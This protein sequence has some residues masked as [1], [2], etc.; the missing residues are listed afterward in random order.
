[1]GIVLISLDWLAN[2]AFGPFAESVSAHRPCFKCHWT[3]KCG[4]A[5]IARTDARNATI[6]HTAL[7]RRKRLRTHDETMQTVREMRAMDASQL[8]STKTEEGLF[9]LYFASEYLL[10]D[11]V[12]DA[13]VDI[14]H[15]FLSSGVVPYHLSWL[16]DILIPA[17]FSWDECNS[18]VR[19]YNSKRK[20]HHIPKIAPTAKSDRGSAKLPLTAGE[21]MEFAVASAQI[22]GPLVKDHGTPHWV[23]WLKLVALLRFCLRR[24]FSPDMDAR[25]VQ[26]LYDDWMRSIEHVPQWKGRWKPKHH[27]G[28]HLAQALGEHGPWRAFWCMWGEAF[29]QYLK[30]LFNMTNYRGAVHTVATTWA[31]TAKQRY[32]DPKRVLWHQD[33]VEALPDSE[34]FKT[35]QEMSMSPAM[36]HGVGGDTPSALRPLG[37]FSRQGVTIQRAD[38]VMVTILAEDLTVVGRI[39]EILQLHVCLDTRTTAVVRL[40]L[41][42]VVKPVFD[43]SD[44]VTVTTTGESNCLYVPLE[45]A[46]VS[47]MCREVCG[48][49]VRLRLP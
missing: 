21:A 46:H 30:H 11:L 6:V 41:E 10:D 23:S 12:V 47:Y 44:M 19:T 5:W 29:L 36:A 20:G 9:S 24:Q 4:C 26:T 38:W 31:A 37:S 48:S 15:I 13:T 3:D 18:A 25:R 17:D 32:R 40:L 2:G 16:F 43:A 28:D 14:M 7:C 35:L 22:L 34:E 45:C 49:V 42:H 1:L 39:S 33:A 8:K 27:L